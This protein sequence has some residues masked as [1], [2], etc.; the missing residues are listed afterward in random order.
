MYV[1]EPLH[2]R[3]RVHT[4]RH[5]IFMVFSIMTSHDECLRVLRLRVTPG[6]PFTSCMGIKAHQ[7][8]AASTETKQ[9]DTL[10]CVGIPLS[11]DEFAMKSVFTCFGDV[12]N[13]VM[14]ANKAS[15]SVHSFY[16]HLDHHI[17]IF[18]MYDFHVR[19]RIVT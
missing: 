16:R 19:Y 15:A 13:V 8:I 12:L 9:S 10:F 14:H 18:A 3:Y 6:S 7:R 17:T 4:R 2:T 5:H 11:F 1:S